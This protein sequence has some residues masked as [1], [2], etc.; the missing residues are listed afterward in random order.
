MAAGVRSKKLLMA[1]SL[2]KYTTRS[3]D[4]R[5]TRKHELVLDDFTAYITCDCL[6]GYMKKAEHLVIPKQIIWKI[7]VAT[8]ARSCPLMRM[9]PR[10]VLSDE[11]TSRIQPVVGS[12]G[13]IDVYENVQ[14]AMYKAH[15]T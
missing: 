3:A 6:P 14:N 5:K 7:E 2:V 4:G 10:E 12:R 1:L 9:T 8:I 15:R 13:L 11:L